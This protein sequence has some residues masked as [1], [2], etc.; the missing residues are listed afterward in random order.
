M[1]Q[2]RRSQ[3]GLHLA[4]CAA[5][6]LLAGPPAAAYTIEPDFYTLTEEYVSPHIAWAKPFGGGK[7][8]ALFIVPRG[9]AREVIE[10]AQRLDLDY[11]VV[12]TLS[13]TELGWTSASSHYALAEGISQEE[14]VAQLREVLAGEYDVIVTGRLNWDIFP[15]E[16]LYEVMLKVREG[17]GLVHSYQR[18]GRNKYVDLLFA[19]PGVQDDFVAMGVPWQALPVW[20]ELGIDRVLELRQFGAGRM[21]LLDH[22]PSLPRFMFLTPK[23]DDTDWSYRELH[24]EYYQ[25]LAARAIIWAARKEPAVRFTSIGVGADTI[26]RAELPNALLTAKLASPAPGLTAHILIQDEDKRVALE[27]DVTVTGD[28]VSVGLPTV[29]AGRYFADVSLRNAAGVVNWA[30]TAFTVTSEPAIAALTL[31]ITHAQPGETVTAQVSLSGGAPADTSLVIEA[32]DNLGRVMARK[33]AALAAGETD[34]DVAFRVSNPIALSA[35][36]L[37]TLQVGGEVVDRESA[38]LYTPIQRTRGRFAHAVWS[39]DSNCNE[40]VRRIMLRQLHAC[41]VDMMTN[42]SRSAEIQA[43]SARNN[44]DTIPYATRYSYS[45]SDLVRKPCLTDPQYLTTELGNLQE[46]GAALGPFRPRAY[47]LG[48][49]CFLSSSADVC[50]SE[51]CTAD[52]RRWLQGEY[53]TVQEL[54]ASWGTNYASFDEAEP[55]TLADAREAAQP[56]RWVDHRR[57]MEF[58]YARMMERA[59]A[60]IQSA[61]PR[62][63]VGFDGPFATTSV[64]GNDWWRLM[65]VFDMCNLY[66]RPEEWEPMR[67]FAKPGALL[68]VWYGGY[69]QY[70]NEDSERLWPWRALLNGMNSMWWYAVYHGLTTCPMDA[71]TPSMTIYPS[72]R[73]ASEEIAEL[74]GGPAQALMNARRLHDGIAVHYSQSSVH[75]ATWSPEFGP[76]DH[77]WLATYHTLE[78]MGLQYDCYAVAQLEQQGLDP[79]QYPVL[80]MPHSQAISPAEARAIRAYVQAGGTVIADVQPGVC[81][82]HGKPASPG[83]LDEL[84]GIERV[85]GAGVLSAVEGVIDGLSAE[86]GRLTELD[87]DGNVRPLGATAMGAAGEVP[88]VLINQTGAGRT[89]LLNYSFGSIDRQRMEAEALEHWRVLRELLAMAGVA[90]Q[91]SVTAGGEPLRMLETVRYADGPVQ[92][93]GFVKYRTGAEEP[94]VTARIAT[95]ERMHTWDVRSGEYLGEVDAWDARFTPSRGKLFARTPYRVDALRLSL[96]KGAVEA[97]EREQFAVVACQMRL[98]VS[99]T[100]PGRHWV[101]VRVF[102]P[103]GD[104]RRHYARNVALVG[105]TGVTYIPM[106]LNDPAG[107][108]RVVA[109]DVIS[110]AT[111]EGSFEL[112]T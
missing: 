6:A 47:T 89:V 49:E 51:T 106:A 70:R 21:A 68:G 53:E 45:G 42:S 13:D 5:C 1:G 22:G 35:D 61:D 11:R 98:Q 48:D 102:G 2:P 104:E 43:W 101:N 99:G 60:A 26:D 27:E 15:R 44:F 62:A 74:R 87:V 65:Q 71:L 46:L 95:G 109:R 17:T 12:M 78:D 16:Q 10:I 41:G 88:L 93:L 57:H 103:D 39:A 100:T 90:P 94:T 81:D 33:Y 34:V 79:A 110:G 111:A 77:T 50:F 91:V 56:A 96:Q 30:S 73:W 92:Y 63:E 85:D 58:V 29:P 67:S 20:R 64:S 32:I 69:F 28:T 31:D 66:E 80:V 18:F 8:R 54:N 3:I 19:K 25:S 105:E 14:M 40:F 7:I 72:F 9:T 86:P 76:L 23:P 52:L 59:R 75:A 36:V 55:I 112:G 37:A 82:H 97:N 84:F 38:W 108:W 107:T 4:L 83:L 24:Y